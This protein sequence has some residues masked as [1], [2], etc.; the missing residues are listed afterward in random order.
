VA[1]TLENGC[2]SKQEGTAEKSRVAELA[3]KLNERAANLQNEA[4]WTPSPKEVKKFIKK[5]KQQEVED[6]LRVQR[7]EVENLNA[8]RETESTGGD[9]MRFLQRNQVSFEGIEMPAV[10][11]SADGSGERQKQIASQLV[12]QFLIISNTNYEDR[13]AVEN[14]MKEFVTENP[15]VKS[16]QGFALAMKNFQS[17]LSS[18]GKDNLQ[19]KTL[20]KMMLALNQR[21][22]VQPA[23]QVNNIV[24]VDPEIAKDLAQVPGSCISVKYDQASQ[25]LSVTGKSGFSNKVKKQDQDGNP[26]I[27]KPGVGDPMNYMVRCD[28]TMQMDLSKEEPQ[29]EQVLPQVKVGVPSSGG[30]QEMA[31]AIFKALDAAGMKPTAFL[32]PSHV[33]EDYMP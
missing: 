29:W 15:D 4:D 14:M 22:F 9:W 19:M 32:C 13:Q 17:E 7:S 23:R 2:A 30:D 6:P 27:G 16:E 18:A 10:F 24:K 11:P 20:S 3:G 28:F 1:A 8:Q 25:V 12:R 5:L 26:F 31:K 21:Y 33:H